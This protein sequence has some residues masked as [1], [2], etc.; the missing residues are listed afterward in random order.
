MKWNLLFSGLL[1]GSFL[2]ASPLAAQE[3]VAAAAEREE[4]EANFKRMNSRVEQLEETLQT[5]QKR[6]GALVD[7]LHSLRELVDRL[8][9]KS[10]GT[11][12]QDAITNFQRPRRRQRDATVARLIKWHA[13]EWQHVG[14]VNHPQQ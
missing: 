7:E 13:P 9:G 8:K 10:E 1:A 4:M 3:S 12:T 5:Q 11:A 6:M 14:D 2:L